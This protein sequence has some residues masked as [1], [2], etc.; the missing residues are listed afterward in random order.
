M[1]VAAF[2][3]FH[4]TQALVV[5]I[6]FGVDSFKVV[7]VRPGSIDIVLNEGSG[8]KTVS[9]L[10]YSSHG[11]VFGDQV[12]QLVCQNRASPSQQK[13]E[14][15]FLCPWKVPNSLPFFLF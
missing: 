10:G 8:R 1:L 15:C 6:D 13:K 5:G 2:C 11:R 7:L 4:V 12:Q 9:S 14:K 3:V